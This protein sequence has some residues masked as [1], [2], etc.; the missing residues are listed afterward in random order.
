MADVKRLETKTFYEVLG[1]PEDA[2][3]EQIREVYREVARIYH[4]DSNFYDE[5]VPQKASGEQVQIF[6][7]ITAAYNTLIDPNKRAEYDRSVAPLLSLKRKVKDWDSEVEEFTPTRPLEP[8]DSSPPHSRPRRMTATFGKREFFDNPEPLV[9]APT[10]KPLSKR[11]SRGPL[12]WFAIGMGIVCGAAV[13][14]VTYAFIS[15]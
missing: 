12:A 11:S 7:I 13:G 14:A 4:P 10:P 1:V 6:K 8:Q 3:T 5:I 15:S 2:S 9:E